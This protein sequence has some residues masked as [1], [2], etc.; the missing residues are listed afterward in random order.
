MK[1]ILSVVVSLVMMF[2]FTAVSI[3]AEQE[4]APA[5]APV[6]KTEKV[7]K[8]HHKAVHH[9]RIAGEVTA[10]DAAAGTITVKHK[11]GEVTFTVNDKTGFKAGKEKKSIEDVKAGEKVTVRYKKEE[12]K[13]V[14]TS[15]YIWKAKKAE[16]KA[17]KKEAAP[18]EKQAAP[19]GK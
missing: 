8:K 14:A 18:A 13:D 12:G 9:G 17:E 15:V 7:E 2:A 19:A 10:V 11:K 5:K 3:A 4:A 6:E 16:K 1:K